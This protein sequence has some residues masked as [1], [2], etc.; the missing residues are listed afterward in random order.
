M[1]DVQTI[2]KPKIYQALGIISGILELMRPPYSNLI[3]GD[4][5][6]SVTVSQKAE[7]K[8]EPGQL[9]NF[10][11]YPLVTKGKL[12]FSLL[13]AIKE[14]PERSRSGMTLKGCWVMYGDEPRLIIY[15]N[16][17]KNSGESKTVLQL[18]WEEAPVADGKYWEIEA[19]VNGEQIMVIEAIGPFDPPEKFYGKKAEKKSTGIKSDVPRPMLKGAEPR[20]IKSELPPPILKSARTSIAAIEPPESEPT[21]ETANEPISLNASTAIEETT[22]TTKAAEV[23]KPIAASEIKEIAESSSGAIEPEEP[24]VSPVVVEPV[25]PKTKKASGK[26]SASK[27]LSISPETAEPKKTKEKVKAS[28]SKK[29]MS[30]AA[31]RLFLGKQLPLGNEQKIKIDSLPAPVAPVL[32]SEDPPPPYR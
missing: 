8:Y 30:L 29:P 32:A 15:R 14:A 7:E 9:Q 4:H 23:I 11:V 31:D 5:T 10:K 16:K 19:E 22:R 24:E 27:K 2:E 12:G 28:S 18:A 13:M 26:S 25:T 20:E 3:V 1:E 6:Y 17:K 21:I